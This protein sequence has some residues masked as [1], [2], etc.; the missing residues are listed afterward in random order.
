MKIFNYGDDKKNFTGVCQIVGVYTSCPM[1]DGFYHCET[2]PATINS[3][4]KQWFINGELHREDG[5]AV[6]RSN[7][8]KEWCYKDE[9]HGFNN[10]FTVKSWKKYIEKLKAK[11]SK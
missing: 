3:D 9:C 8:E 1:K 7:G 10:D 11:E 5:P 4:E 2:G 6:E